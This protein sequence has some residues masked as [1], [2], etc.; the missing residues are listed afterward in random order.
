F[1]TNENAG[2]DLDAEIYGYQGAVNL[3]TYAFNTD[4]PVD[5]NFA[6][7]YYDYVNWFQTILAANNTAATSYLRTNSLIADDFRVLDLY[8]E[9]TFYVNRT[10]VVLWYD[11]ATNLADTGT[12]DPQSLGNDIHDSDNAWGYGIKIGK[13]KKKGNWEA[14]YGYYEIGVNAVV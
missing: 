1:I 8:P 3:S 13:I 12:T 14:F 10:P 9:V 6:T 4:Q 7:S 11:Y 5:I 2:I